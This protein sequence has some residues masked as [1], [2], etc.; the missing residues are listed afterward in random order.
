MGLRHAVN[1]VATANR[2][3]EAGGGTGWSRRGLNEAV[4]NRVPAGFSPG[5][6][7]FVGAA[8]TRTAVSLQFIV[9][10]GP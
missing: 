9:H 5:G 6:R 2:D 8:G 10:I 1:G 4:Y 7:R 3:T